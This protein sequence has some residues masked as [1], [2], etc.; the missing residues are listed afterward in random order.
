MRVDQGQIVEITGW[1]R[2]DK[3]FADGDGLHIVDS[4]GGPELSLIVGQTS[5]WQTFRMV[6]A[7]GQMTELRLTFALTGLG[8]AKVDAV[9]VRALQQPIARRLPT[10]S[11]TRSTSATSTGDNS[12]PLLVVPNSR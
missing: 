4:L 1:V 9:M 11:G 7:A 3:P 6:R 12:G 8:S 10:V 5:G 2:I